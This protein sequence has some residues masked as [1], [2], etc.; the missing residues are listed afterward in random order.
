VIRVQLTTSIENDEWDR[1]VE[2]TPHGFHEQTSLWSQV[3]AIYG[4]NPLRV[5]LSDQEGIVA[6]SQILVRTV[7]GRFRVGFVSRGPV[8]SPSNAELVSRTV[9]TICRVARKEKLTYLAIAPP[10]RGEAVATA[11]HTEGFSRKPDALPPGSVMSATLLVD[12][13]PDLDKIQARMRA[14]V[15]QHIRLAQRKG[16]SVREGGKEDVET[17]RVLMCSL[18]QRRGI[19]PTPPE[20]DFFEHLWRV[21]AARGWVRIFLAEIGG[22]PVAGLLV[23]SFGDSARV[24]KA[25]WS[26]DFAE[27]RPNNLLYWEA[28]R[29]AKQ[30]GFR[31]FDMVGIEREL[32]EQLIAGSKIDWTKVAGPDNFKVGYGGEPLVLPE[33]CYRF[34]NPWAQLALRA[35]GQ[36]LVESARVARVL[37]RFN[38]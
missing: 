35:G 5:T 13:S 38:G 15:R 3:K 29:W 25:G 37:E 27:C 30:N 12:L 11:L 10:Y 16:V 9:E 31:R 28:I 4:W 26:G 36:Q 6:G 18:C 7:R 14:Q 19:S 21:F 32:G 34:L 1:F 24:W 2:R 22:R 23:F 20:T 33:T 8:V 17:F